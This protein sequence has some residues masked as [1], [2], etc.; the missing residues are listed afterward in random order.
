MLCG[1]VLLFF[2]EGLAGRAAAHK[3]TVFAW[4]EGDTVYTQSK[5]AGGRKAK[6]AAVEVYDQAGKKLLEGK[7]DEQGEFSFTAPGKMQMKIVLVAGVGHRGEWVI[8]ESEFADMA[9]AAP[10]KEPEPLAPLVSKTAD[11]PASGSSQDSMAGCV[12]REEVRQMLDAALDK[13]L[14]PISM[15]VHKLND[16]DH[17]PGASDIAGGIGYIF[18]LVGVAAYV[19]SR[20]KRDAE[21]AG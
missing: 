6:N 8:R 1:L 3:V 16:P 11:P 2:L 4:V 13:K 9:E 10:Q 20:R 17:T 21:T 18:G 5:F 12:T 14:R 19:H 15:A 7:T